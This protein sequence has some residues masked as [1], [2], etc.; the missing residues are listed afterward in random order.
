MGCPAPAVVLDSYSSYHRSWNNDDKIPKVHMQTDAGYCAAV[1]SRAAMHLKMTHDW[2]KVT[3]L[4]CLRRRP[5][6]DDQ[7]QGDSQE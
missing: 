2:D 1:L 7:L 3:C 5:L 6:D 4:N